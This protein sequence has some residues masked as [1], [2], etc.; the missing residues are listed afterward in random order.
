MGAWVAEAFYKS[1]II[2]TGFCAC[3]WA[4]NVSRE[5]RPEGMVLPH[6]LLGGCTRG[7]HKG[8]YIYIYI[9]I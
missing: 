1:T 9:Y 7:A 4:K 2:L 6:I 8:G 5:Y 3:V